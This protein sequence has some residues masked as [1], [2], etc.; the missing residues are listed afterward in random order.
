MIRAMT[1]F[2][3]FNPSIDNMSA[4]TPAGRGDGSLFRIM[5]HSPTTSIGIIHP[6]QMGVSVA[7]SLRASGHIVHWASE[8]R[9]PATTARAR[10]LGLVDV[11][12]SSAMADRCEIIFS[13]CPP[14][15]AEDVARQVA[16]TAFNGI[17]V[18]A[19]AISPA[20]TTEIGRIVTAAGIRFVDGG[21][22]GGPAI[23]SGTTWLHLSGPDAPA[24][25]A[26]F[27]SG[28][29]H[30]TQL[31]DEIGQASALKMC[32]AANTKGTTALMGAVLG[33]AEN[34]G[35]R[36]ALGKQWDQLEEGRAREIINR[37]RGVMHKAWRFRGEMDEIAATFAAAG[38]PGDF[39]RGAS[40]IYRRVSAF[41][42]AD[43]PPELDAILPLLTDSASASDPSISGASFESPETDF[44]IRPA[45]PEDVP[46]LLDMIR[47]L[48]EYERMSDCVTATAESL[49]KTLFGPRPFAAALLAETNEGNGSEPVGMAIF[50]E[51][52]ST[53]A[54]NVGLHLED[55]YV[56]P[57]W[58]N[59]GLGRAL[60]RELA[61][62]AMD[63]G[64]GWLEWWVLDWNTP[65][66]EFYEKLGS[67]SLD[68][69]RIFKLDLPSEGL[70]G[71][72]R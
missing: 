49:R 28:P 55:L 15:A 22:V 62:L 7:A 1:R 66:I 26:C 36:E 20:R 67:R 56:R 50:F 57:E 12:T 16:D 48:A 34:L 41:K 6:G 51:A 53:F 25:G 9:S 60:L 27:T 69:W 10:K 42:D 3:T 54:A 72:L 68:D 23:H 44:R 5:L 13:I 31:G 46:V 32:F 59:R 30:V 21:I 38:M 2:Y 47:G 70:L 64:Y 61:R 19:N 39:H 37:V 52:Y 45:V 40:E 65:A 33:A 11:E 71:P 14:H 35:V 29:L 43:P 63:R 4:V 58:R 17:F 8:G 24:V 18:D